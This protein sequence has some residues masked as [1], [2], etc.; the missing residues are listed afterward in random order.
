MQG[1]GSEADPEEGPRSRMRVRPC[2]GVEVV[3]PLL[4]ARTQA[5]RAKQREHL[6]LSQRTGAPLQS[7]ERATRRGPLIPAFPFALAAAARA[8]THPSPNWSGVRVVWI[9]GVCLVQWIVCKGR[10]AV[11]QKLS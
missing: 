8:L 2:A 1:Q 10:H 3:F 11:L 9:W 7:E 5:I 6:A 4:I